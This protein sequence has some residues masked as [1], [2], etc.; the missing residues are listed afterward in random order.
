MAGKGLCHYL[1]VKIVTLLQLQ[2]F[3]ISFAL[4]NLKFYFIFILMVGKINSLSENNIKILRLFVCNL[5]AVDLI[6][7]LSA[8]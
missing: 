2:K 3:K 4:C 1:R 5:F 7:N 6:E 8:N